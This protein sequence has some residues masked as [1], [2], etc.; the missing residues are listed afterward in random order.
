MPKFELD[1]YTDTACADTVDPDT[2]N[3]GARLKFEA[4][5]VIQLVSENIE[6]FTKRE[7]EAAKRGKK[8]YHSLGCPSIATIK[9]LIH[10]NV[11]RNCPVTMEDIVI[12]KKIYGPDPSKVKGKSTRLQPPT[13][14]NDDIKLPDKLTGRNDLVLCM[15]IM[16]VW[17]ILFLTT[18]NKLI[19]FRAAVPLMS[20]SQR[21]IQ[22]FGFC[23]TPVQRCWIFFQ[24]HPL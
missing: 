18:I 2:K 5:L 21:S 16:F 15:D 11:I 9:N 17:G 10:M 3:A 7:V 24:V 22:S 12:A 14:I 23:F 1:S 20:K 8:F 13:V 19:C 6:G 4:Q